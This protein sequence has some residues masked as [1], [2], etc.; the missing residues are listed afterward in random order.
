MLYLNIEKKINQKK[1][2]LKK[3]LLF[4]LPLLVVLLVV[5][6]FV[7]DKSKPDD[8]EIEVNILD[9]N[10]T[11]ADPRCPNIDNSLGALL[12][13]DDP[14]ETAKRNVIE[15]REGR[16]E[17]EVRLSEGYTSITTDLDFIEYQYSEYFHAIFGSVKVEDLCD[18]ANVPGVAYI[19]RSTTVGVD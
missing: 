10:P 18:L 9:L 11:V 1:L 13:T 19:K 15:I 6:F 3:Y 2:L 16:V 14:L 12:T 17:V 5:F 4:T 7:F 8:E